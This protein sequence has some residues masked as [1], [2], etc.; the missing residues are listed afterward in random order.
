MGL[1]TS[2]DCWQ[3][4]YSAFMRWR[5]ALASVIG[6]DLD[7]MGGYT[8]AE[9]AGDWSDVRIGVTAEMADLRAVLADAEQS[10][11]ADA[12]AEIQA[13]IERRFPIDP[14]VTL[15]LHSDCDGSIEVADLL[16]LANR[17]EELLP[18]LEEYDAANEP[19]GHLAA[20]NPHRHAYGVA[21]AARRFAAGLRL[22]ASLGEPV[23]F[24]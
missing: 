2:H 21:G 19:A 15:L 22:A 3:G 13:E 20:V 24:H 9:D 11:R 8:N 5:K 16:P 1:D 7:K 23:E 10:D 12:V 6:L 17:L 14:L 4:A 18:K